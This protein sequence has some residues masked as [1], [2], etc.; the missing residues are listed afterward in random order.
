[1]VIGMFLLHG[2]TGFSSGRTHSE[3]H[4][5]KDLKISFFSGGIEWAFRALNGAAETAAFNGGRRWRWW[6]FL[7]EHGSCGRVW[8]VMEWQVRICMVLITCLLYLTSVV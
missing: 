1:M 3:A 6:A 7:E 5:S 8:V 4:P 2:S